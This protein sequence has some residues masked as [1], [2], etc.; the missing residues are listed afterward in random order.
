MKTG[1][2][3]YTFHDFRL[4]K[5]IYIFVK[6]KVPHLHPDLWSSPPPPP[7]KEPQTRALPI[8]ISLKV[9]NESREN[10]YCFRNSGHSRF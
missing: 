10:Y 2:W 1:A 5:A 8:S 7:E 9:E 3:V 6:R 4:P